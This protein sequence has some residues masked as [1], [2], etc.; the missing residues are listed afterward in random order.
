[1]RMRS[2]LSAGQPSTASSTDLLQSLGKVS[3]YIEAA[4]WARRNQAQKGN[5]EAFVFQ[6]DSLQ[7]SFHNDLEAM[8]RV[9]RTRTKLVTECDQPK[10]ACFLKFW[11]RADEDEDAA[12]VKSTLDMPDFPSVADHHAC[13]D[14]ITLL[15]NSLVQEVGAM[16]EALLI[17][18]K[19]IVD[20]V[21]PA[22][23]DGAET[24]P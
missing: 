19:T 17:H 24:W 12:Y 14:L 18:V 21:L 9:L 10:K 11:V 2:C 23:G 20:P 6:S 3:E 4:E 15:G 13:F 5:L 1:M 22:E 16:Q 8:C 7:Q